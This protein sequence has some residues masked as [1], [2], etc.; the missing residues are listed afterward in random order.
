MR[1]EAKGESVDA[2][3]LFESGRGEP[4]P[5]TIVDRDGTKAATIG[6][7]TFG[8]ADYGQVYREQDGKKSWKMFDRAPEDF[9]QMEHAKATITKLEKVAKS[10]S[11]DPVWRSWMV[12][13]PAMASG[14]RLVNRRPSY[15][16]TSSGDAPKRA[17]KRGHTGCH[18]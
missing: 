14:Q 17:S 5:V 11:I 12:S 1:F 10:G 15:V 18:A 2:V 6:S 9:A 16:V 8:V 7:T 3:L 13:A 4:T